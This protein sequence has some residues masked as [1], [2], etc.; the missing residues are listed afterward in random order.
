MNTKSVL[1]VA[2]HYPPILGSSGVHRTLAFTRY[3][4][5]ND[6]QVTVLTVDLVAYQKW[7][8]DQLNFIPEKAK[9]IR[10]FARDTAKH[11]SVKGKYLAW[12]ALPDNLQ[13][14]IIGGVLS[15]LKDIRRNKPSVI[16]STYPIASAHFIGYIL[17]K[18][19][20]I[21]WVADL[22]DPMAQPGY[23]ADKKKFFLFNWIERKIVKHASKAILTAPGAKT[24]Y[25]DKFP[26]V[27]ETFWQVIPNGYD[28]VIFDEIANELEPATPETDE[29]KAILHSGVIY[30]H[31]RDPTALFQAFGQLK[32][33]GV[34]SAN[35]L[36]IRLRATGH[37]ELYRPM[38]EKLEI[39][40]IVK[41]LPP[42]EY[43]EALKEM[44]TVDGLLL[45]QSE[46]CNY[47]IP[48]KAY[49]YIRVNNPI[50][51][52][53]PK[54]G[55]T[56]QLVQ[57][58]GVQCQISSLTDKQDIISSIEKFVNTLCVET[59]E[60]QFNKNTA[61]KYSRGEQANMFEQM[62]VEAINSQN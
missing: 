60:E 8:P 47:Q 33:D 5:E 4:S 14:W 10:A 17:H 20:G 49:E 1:Y 24:F 50:L 42:I 26:N 19:S 30:P 29:K 48:A 59:K 7:S 12:M 27:D 43:K 36:E 23:P 11:L 21:P 51:A 2:Y 44:F 46:G 32:R 45:M 40:D 53:T 55:D 9:V 3:L 38:L 31:E 62:L 54:E 58:S 61:T 34:I 52:L 35:S 56:A 13:S 39:E 57:H 16:V 25:Q 6:W 15:G 18:I 28:E 37:D 22:R 41:L